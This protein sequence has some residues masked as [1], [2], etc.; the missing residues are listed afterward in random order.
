[1]WRFDG[2]DST[3]AIRQWRFRSLKGDGGSQR[4]RYDG[5]DRC[6]RGAILHQPGTRRSPL[7]FPRV[8]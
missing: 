7:S 2:G 8:L 1:R 5:E 3:V 4:V 6:F